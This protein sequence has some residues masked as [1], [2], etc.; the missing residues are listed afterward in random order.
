MEQN[1]NKTRIFFGSCLALLVTSLTF[2]MRAKIE[3][4]FGPVEGGGIFGLSKDVIGWAFSPAFWGFTI[5][6]VAG[7]F[8]IDIVKTRT[9]I[10]SAFVLQ[11]IGGIIFIMAHDK[12]TLFLAN[13]FIGLGNGTVEA[14]FNPLIATIYPKNKT[15]MLNRFHVW[16][17]GGIVIGSLLAYLMVDNMAINWQIF[18]GLLFIPL[19]LYGLLFLG[20]KIPETERVS[21]GV[22][23]KEMLSAIG[24]PVTIIIAMTL[25][26]LLATDIIVLPAGWM[27][28]AFIGVVAAIS[29]IEAKLIRKES[30]IF[31]V[32]FT[33]MMLTA[34]TELVTNQWVNALLSNA[35]VSAMLILALISGIM[36]LGRFFAGHL[37]HRLHPVGVLLFSA[38]F[39]AIGIY[40]LSLFSSPAL[41]IVSAIFFAIG[42]CYF[43]PTMLGFT[44]EYIPRS[45]ALGLSLLGGAG[46]VS[47]AMF[48]PVMGRILEL[49]NTRVALQSIGILPLILIVGFAILFVAY[50]N[51]KPVEL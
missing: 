31:P 50:R 2:A 6:M 43:W 24:A 15:K 23:Y 4:I 9:L 39:S 30:I 11:L 27:Y 3:E 40:S 7:G 1:F 32:M 10:W 48:L 51:K 21:S 36:A 42:V 34:A 49:R 44:S 16:F 47:T 17:P 38:V 18:A 20:Q 5:A 12:E 14:S 29:L 33:F 26:V 13:V 8:I 25:M 28:L 22:T 19:A 37:T 46:F 45:G 41:T 35:G